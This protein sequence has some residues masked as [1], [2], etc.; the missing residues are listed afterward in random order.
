MRVVITV[1]IVLIAVF[2]ATFP[3]FSQTNH[4][5]ISEFATRGPSSATD[6]FVELYNPTDNPISLSGWKLQYSAA[7]NG[8][9]WS[10]RAII[11]A[12]A[13]IPARGFFLLANTSY[14]GTVT[15]DYTSSLWT[16]GTGMAD[17]GHERI[18]DAGSTEIDKVGWGNAVNPEGGIPAPNHGTTANN[19]SV[20]RKFRENST[21]DSL[22]AGGFHALLGNGHDTNVNGNDY[23]TQTHGRNP[24]NSLS[25]PEPPSAAGSGSASISPLEING[26]TDT[27]VMLVYHRDI[28]YSITALRIIVPSEFEWSQSTSD[29]SFNNMT[30]T[31]SVSN[32]TILFSDIAF[33]I[34]STEITISNMTTAVFTGYYPFKVQSG[35]VGSFGDVAPTPRITV[36]GASIPI[37][38]TKINDTNGVALR[39][40]DLVTVQGIIT[41]GNE[42]GSPSYIQDNSG[43][44]SIF[45]TIFSSSVIIG[46]EVVV[47]ARVAQF[48]G[49]N[50]IELPIQQEIL[51]SGNSVEPLLATPTQLKNDGLGGVENYEGLLVRLNGVTVTDLNGNPVAS[52]AGNTNYRLVGSSAS[53]T[54][55]LRV[56]NNT[57]LVGAVAP[58][59]VFDVIGVLGQFKTTPP[60]IGGYQVMPRSL[61]DVI[62][63]GP[64][65]SEFPH[66]AN[67]TSSSMTIYFKTVNPGTSRLRYGVTTAYELGVVEPDN[68]PRTNHLI[69]LTDLT[70]ATIYH[71]QAFSVAGGDTSFAGDLIVSTSSPS[72]TTGQINVYFT[73][74]VD[75]SV[76]RGEKALGNVNLVNKVVARIN[77]ARRSIDVAL[78]SLSGTPGPGTDVANAL[79]NA[80]N[81]GVIVR[82]IGEYDNR[83]TSP[84]STLSN[85]GIP[86][87]FDQ[88]GAND[89]SGLHH[90]KFF[91][92]DYK[93]GAPESVWV[94]TGSWN[95]TEPGTNNDRQNVIEIQDVALAGAYTAEFEEM[96][97]SST[98]T[99]NSTLSRFG[100]R[101][102]DNVPHNFVINGV[103]VQV[104]F[105]PGDRTRS[106]IARVLGHAQN[107]VNIAMLT[108]TRQD[109]ADSLIAQKNRG[110]NVR[111]VM[112]ENVNT[113]NQFARL[114]SAGVDVLL[115]GFT[116]ALLHHKYAVIDA[117][118]G[119]NPGWTITG[120][121]NWSS[122]A[123]NSNDENTIIIQNDR[124][125]NLYLQ[126]FSARYTEAGGTNPIVLGVKEIDDAV[127][128]TFVLSQNYPNPF[129]PKTVFSFQ[130]PVSSQ[131]SLKVYDILGQQVVTLVSEELKAGTYAVQWD[132]SALAS[133]VYF[134][135]I[136][137]GSFHDIKKMV[138]MK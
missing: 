11:P 57:N 24:Q 67:I 63:E 115:K 70:A 61:S 111:V 54:V 43:G 119:S 46:D 124:V 10:D 39:L 37:A 100:S 35:S 72:G 78:Y 137:A 73:K 15:P 32:D 102:T 53:D 76:A 22:A 123:E 55:Q 81:R 16:S 66:E 12:D 21:S 134:Y 96:W 94:W 99:P 50:Q 59:G 133:G 64:I 126:E 45:G 5:V 65:I 13:V 135:Q 88:Y 89:G 44:M 84:W 68:T 118:P 130:L 105:S 132:A 117:E 28:A 47:T 56:D 8:N 113:G 86:V 36:F 29:I 80:K 42:F 51:S 40:G 116:G 58:A 110:R 75:T 93:G 62:S 103:P 120:S 27:T 104:S 106:R 14:N 23:V 41:V 20:E 107:S 82:V 125:A 127:P 74:M 85:N 131:V 26:S 108:F 95:P 30:A 109:L 19:N 138:L 114:Q 77:N 33:T 98:Q 6:E 112:D 9:T 52:W 79:V 136:R 128:Q 3:L 48:N 17:N 87:I 4:I 101:K 97:G 7:S 2:N 60:Y 25:P 71:V 18:I 34:D 1:F 122:S 92:F 31:L 129:N 49:L 121:Y 90:N 91:V 69:D 38:D 83:T